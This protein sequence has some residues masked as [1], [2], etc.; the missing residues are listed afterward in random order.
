ME[1]PYLIKDFSGIGGTIKQRPE[2]FFVQELPLYEPSGEGEHLYVQIQKVKIT[3]FEAINRLAKALGVRSRDIGYAGMKDAFAITQQTFSLAGVRDEQLMDLELPGMQVMWAMRHGNKLRLGHL[4]GN[5]F[6]IKV[7]DVQPTDV[8][9]LRPVLQQIELVGLPNYFGEQRFG[10][11]GDNH[12]LGAALV[13]GDDQ[14]LLDQLLGAPDAKVDDAQSLEARMAYVQGDYERSMQY[15]PG[16]CG[17]EKSVLARLMKNGPAAAARSVDRKLRELWVSALQSAVFNE[18]VAAR[19]GSLNRLI[20]GDIAMKHT[21]GACFVVEDRQA[22]QSRVDAWEI[23]PTGPMPGY[24]AMAATGEMGR[25]EQTVMQ[26]YSLSHE[27]FRGDRGER[28]RGERR[29][30]R[31]RPTNIQIEGGVDNY[32]PHIT[33]A[34][35]LPPGA[36]AT[37]LLREVMRGDGASRTPQNA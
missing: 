16:P 20:D 10:R 26:R 15:W 18:V 21:N 4:A 35:T 6:A 2:D 31:V 28:A 3:T 23:S 13:R 19:I 25:I 29:A 33:L 34:F 36:F 8:V 37:T 11:R 27:S 9:R 5:R 12:L 24:K 14:A 22:E 1:L 7:R 32:G 17:L 30:L